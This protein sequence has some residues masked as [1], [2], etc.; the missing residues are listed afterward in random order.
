MSWILSKDGTSFFN[1]D[2]IVMVYCAGDFILRVLTLSTDR[3][4]KLGRYSTQ[5]EVETA[6]KIVLKGVMDNKNVQA[7]DDEKVY[8]VLRGT[9]KTKERAANGKKPVRR[10]GS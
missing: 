10:G 7:P 9:N 6:L 2:H 3:S 8:A 4:Y 5:E 1:T